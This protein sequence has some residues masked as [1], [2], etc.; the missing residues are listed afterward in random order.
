MSSANRLVYFNAIMM[1]FYIATY[2]QNA[3]LFP[4]KCENISL[5]FKNVCVHVHLN[6]PA[7]DVQYVY[8]YVCM[9]RVSRVR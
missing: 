2:H 4:K 1:T 5:M 9:Y 3:Q 8:M 6:N 7:S